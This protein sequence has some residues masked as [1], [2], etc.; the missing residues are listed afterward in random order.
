MQ[1]TQEVLDYINAH[2][3]GQLSFYQKLQD[4]IARLCPDALVKWN[5]RIA[6]YYNGNNWVGLGFR[7][8]GISLYTQYIPLI[9]AFREK[10]PQ[11]KYGKGC[12]NFRL[13]DVIPE[14]DIRSLIESV[15]K[16]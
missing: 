10:H 4:I 9:T 12:I 1:F 5:W 2:E 11:L 14:E 8:D 3:G 15:L 6:V 16:I 13:K 7:K